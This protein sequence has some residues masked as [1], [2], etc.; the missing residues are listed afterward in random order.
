[1]TFNGVKRSTSVLLM[2]VSMLAGCASKNEL[3]QRQSQLFQTGIGQSP[4]AIKSEDSIEIQTTKG[5]VAIAPTV[6]GYEPAQIADP[7]ESINRPIFAFNHVVYTW[8]MNPLAKGYTAIM[9]DPAE[10][11]VSQFFSNLREPLNAINHL[12][13]ANGTKTGSSLG[14]FL[15]NSTIGVLGIFDPAD[16]WFDIKPHRATLNDTLTTWDVSYGAFIVLPILGQSDIRNGLS[17]L[18]ETTFAPVTYVSDPPQTQ[19]IQT[20]D[21]FHEF[22]PRASSYETLYK[23]S[24]D[25]Y[26]FFRNMYMQ[27]LLRDKEYQD[28]EDGSP[29]PPKAT[30]T[31]EGQSN[32]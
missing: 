24:E 13:Q 8:V 5:I 12:L 19:Y 15:I 11:A 31:V 17:T 14:R 26:V 2:L 27:S 6:V 25:P 1:M 7:F 29:V 18:T 10:V 21:G 22:S 4:S 30:V 23:E 28:Q 32:D 9:P 3:E 16:A 20:Y